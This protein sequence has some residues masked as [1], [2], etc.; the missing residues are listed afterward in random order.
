[1]SIEFERL[2]ARQRTWSHGFRHTASPRKMFGIGGKLH[3]WVC[4]IGI[5]L[6]YAAVVIAVIMFFGCS[7]HQTTEYQES[8]KYKDD[9]GRCWQLV[10]GPIL[11]AMDPLTG[12]VEE[13]GP[14]AM[15]VPI[16]CE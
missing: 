12:Q 9:H 8:T 13:T 6:A 16:D 11:T 15:F 2:T 5:A 1:M 7:T 4:T 3:R 14:V 10:R